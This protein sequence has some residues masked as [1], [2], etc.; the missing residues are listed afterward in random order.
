M[1]FEPDIAPAPR[2]LKDAMAQK[3]PQD[4]MEA[5]ATTSQRSARRNDEAGL[6]LE[7][8]AKVARKET[9]ACRDSER[10]G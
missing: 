4:I 10:A 8:E 9:S 3:L 7:R 5:T 6:T 1:D 2:N